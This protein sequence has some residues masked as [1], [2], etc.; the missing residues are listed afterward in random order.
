[1]THPTDDGPPEAAPGV[2]PVCP[3]HPDRVSYIRCQRCERP[4]CP[5][6]QREAPVGFQCVDCVREGSKGQR[7][8][9]T[10]F[11]G[12]HTG[13]RPLVT[14]AIVAICVGVYL[15]QILPGSTVTAY[16]DFVP[17][18]AAE[19]PWRFL[20][21]AFVHSPSL[22][23]LHIGFNMYAL[24]LIGPYLEQLL[25]RLR[26][27]ALY[28]VSAVGGSVVFL[29]FAVPDFT[30]RSWF[31]GAVGASGAVFGLFA[32][33]VMINRKLGRDSRAMVGIMGLNFL[34]GFVFPNVAWEAH[35]GGALTGAAVAAA[36]AFAPTGPRRNLV[37]AA[38]VIGVVVVLVALTLAKFASVPTGLL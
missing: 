10:V 36:L 5:E 37:Q 14:Q 19:Q 15:L 6:C 17:R 34:F 2:V 24:W 25:G 29:L 18:L 26:F 12:A 20:T 23:P 33:V 1:M 16:A 32:A 8:A 7:Q 9:R 11:G 28:L 30:S 21:S 27:A 4:V 38:G 3:R 35:L 13:D 22:L 31:T